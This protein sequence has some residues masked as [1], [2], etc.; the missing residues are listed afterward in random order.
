MPRTPKDPDKTPKPRASRG[1]SGKPPAPPRETAA[2]T[3]DVRAGRAEKARAAASAAGFAEG[4]QAGFGIGHQAKTIGIQGSQTLGGGS[5]V[6]PP[7]EAWS[8]DNPPTPNP[9]P[10]GG[11]ELAVHAEGGAAARPTLP[12]LRQQ[13]PLP[14]R[15]GQKPGRG[16]GVTPADQPSR[17]LDALLAK[18][19]ERSV[20][21]REM[22]QTQPMLATHPLVSG[23]QA[24][25]V[26]HRPPR[27]EKS[28]GGHA[29]QARLRVRAQGRPAD[30][31]R[32]AGR[33]RAASTSAA[34]C[35][36]ASPARARP[37]PWRR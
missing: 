37:S 30:R 14:P 34:R 28:E 32:R 36:S 1:K 21:A 6:E 23:E 13:G 17:Y 22:L 11:G 18:P 9:S 20:R 16:S 24:T 27:P 25:F 35:C 7:T 12:A 10:P 29:L 8:P 5:G 31:H 26:P 4:P 33:R 2:G 3:P 15:A 19:A